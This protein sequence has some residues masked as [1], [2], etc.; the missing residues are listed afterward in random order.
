M[1]SE[2]FLEDSE[3]DPRGQWDESRGR[4]VLTNM[5]DFIDNLQG[6]IFE[7]LCDDCTDIIEKLEALAHEGKRSATS[8]YR[9]QYQE[10]TMKIADSRLQ[11]YR[12]F[13]QDVH[14]MKNTT[15]I[16]TGGGIDSG[17]ASAG[18]GS[19]MPSQDASGT[20][21]SDLEL[22]PLRGSPV[23]S[24]KSTAD[25]SEHDAVADEFDESL[26]KV[27]GGCEE[28][29]NGN[30]T[31]NGKSLKEI[32]RITKARCTHDEMRLTARSA[33]RR[34]VEIEIYVPCAAKLR[35]ILEK[36]FA[37]QEGVLN[38]K[39]KELVYQPQMFFGVALQYISPSCWDA[40]VF[41]LRQIRSKTLPHDRLGILTEVCKMIPQLFIQEHPEATNP[42]GADDF[43]PIFIYVLVR[44][45][46]PKLLSLCEELQAFCDP[47][48]RMS[49][50]GYYLAT[51]E[52]SLYHLFEADVELGVLFPVQLNKDDDDDLMD[53]LDDGDADQI[54]PVS[55]ESFSDD[56]KPTKP[57]LERQPSPGPM[58]MSLSHTNAHNSS[59]KVAVSSSSSSGRAISPRR[60]GASPMRMRVD[61][62]DFNMKQPTTVQRDQVKIVAEEEEDLTQKLP[63]I[64]SLV[65]DMP[66]GAITGEGKKPALIGSMD[67]EEGEMKDYEVP[68]GVDGYPM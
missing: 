68:E 25:Y 56:P 24:R 39:L 45:Q 5:K 49:E 10:D 48:Q 32:H 63:D 1:V 35:S 61:P 44:A 2:N 66:S 43:L 59:G 65:V 51:L 7:G 37:E 60:G 53:S 29:S 15:T 27:G 57:V 20:R 38:E 6:V 3:E 17:G 54:D 31:S 13:P 46:I 14:T 50:S 52:A 22:M 23:S 40:A 21:E 67:E 4:R 30:T 34:Q 42:L 12:V 8:I 26:E 33:V 36:C 64:A 11:K 16:I 62:A 58:G 55:H 41:R 18:K 47:D 9:Y 19:R 28:K